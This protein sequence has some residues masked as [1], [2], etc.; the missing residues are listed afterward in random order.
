MRQLASIQRIRK[1]EPILGADAILK[2]SILGWEVVVK[3]G[4][5]K[6]G[7]LCVYCEIDSLLPDQP[8][9]AF[10][11]PHKMRIRTIRLR[12]QISQGICFPLTVLPA[13]IELVEG[14]EVTEVLGVKKYEPPMPAN[15]AGVAKGPFPS[16]I[17]K[18]DETRVQILQ[19]RLNAFQ[20]ESCFI[21]EKLDGSSATY[22]RRDG[23]FGVCSR[24]L[25]L[26]P[27]P[28]NSLWKF[29]EDKQ[30]AEKLATLDRDIALQGEIIGEGIQGNK[31]GIRG[32]TVYFFNAFDI[33]KYQYLN[34]GEFQ[35]LLSTLGLASV[36]VLEKNYQLSNNISELV[37]L[38]I[39]KS[40]LKPVRR[41]GLV[42]RPLNEQRDM[43]GRISFK[44]INPE[45]LLKYE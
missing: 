30:L 10:L 36:P 41:E 18:T 1:L 20:G 24:N 16:W 31:Y 19:D 42:I 26:L 5:F 13:K 45:F 25:E 11:K 40:V 44:V 9:F 43:E 33:D 15:L 27:D 38:S 34:F 8:A 12:G 37:H 35:D 29:A 7:D 23:E 28:K 14:K 2:A 6:E 39:G 22:Y 3:K 21:T 32:Q 17:P 4:E